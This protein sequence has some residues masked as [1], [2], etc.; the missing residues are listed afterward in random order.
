MYR[1][2]DVL[3]TRVE[4][5]DVPAG[6]RIMPTEARQAVLAEG[7]LTGHH[8]VLHGLARYYAM[9]TGGRLIEVIE[10]AE[11]RHQLADGSQ[12]EHNPI[13]LPPG[14]YRQIQQREYVEPTR[15]M[16]A[17]TRRVYD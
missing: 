8:H 16:P 11:L 9:P 1:Q 14:W 7:E 3:L 15:S 5:K 17:R 13:R 2:G 12:A 6:F 4:E 10:P